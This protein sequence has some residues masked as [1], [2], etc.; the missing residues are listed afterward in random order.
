MAHAGMVSYY[1]QFTALSNLA[2]R[3]QGGHTLLL[4]GLGIH[5]YEPKVNR[6][7]GFPRSISPGGV[8][9]DIPI[10]MINLTDGLEPDSNRRYQQ[11][12]GQLSSALE[13]GVLEQ[14]FSTDDE[15]VDAISTVKALSKAN[16]EGQ[17]IY[18]L[19]PQNMAETLPNLNLDPE[20]EAAIESA[21]NAGLEVV[22]HTDPVSVPGWSGGG[23]IVLNP[24]T[25]SGGYLIS[26]GQSGGYSGFS[27]SA[28]ID[29]SIALV[30]LFTEVVNGVSNIFR[31]LITGALGTVLGGVFDFIDLS[32][33]CPT[34]EAIAGALFTG[35]ISN[36]LTNLLVNFLFSGGV[37]L[38]A[39][40]AL[41][42]TIYIIISLVINLIK[43]AIIYN[44]INRDE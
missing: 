18:Q 15:P 9:F 6:L 17:R 22:A 13:H 27:G 4:G 42:L 43:G 3:Q 25:G 19:T 32:S 1:A 29:D 26:G 5:G 37:G 44:C 33:A 39:G 12:I 20:N 30:S 10:A 41:I 14:M 2:G 7:F 11:Q 36:A 34:G 31:Q 24:V 40:I 23:Y 28:G 16:A 8:V 38:I 21:L 35:Y